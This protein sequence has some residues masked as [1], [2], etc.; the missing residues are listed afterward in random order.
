MYIPLLKIGTLTL[1]YPLLLAPLANITDSPYRQICRRQGA[2]MVFTEMVSSE[3][4]LRKSKK[5]FALARFDPSER[6]LGIQ[7]FGPNPAS[8]AEAARRL[9]E[10]EPEVFDLNFGCPVR[11]VMRQGAGARYM[12]NPERIGQAVKALTAALSRPLTVKLRTG[13]TNS[14]TTVIEAARAAEDEGAAAI[15]IHARSTEQGFRGAAN[16]EIIGQVKKAVKIPVIG[17][18]DITGPEAMRSML[19]QTGCDGVMI[20]RGALGNPWIFA[21]CAAALRGESWQAPNANQ[22][23]LDIELHYRLM[24]EQK[25]RRG[26]WEMR[27]HLSWY[28]KSFPGAAEFRVRIF[29]LEDPEEVLTAARAFFLGQPSI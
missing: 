28:G 21:A 17:N 7:L 12:E 27:K 9:E 24:Q 23:W 29:H 22:R 11:K 6:P 10:L 25:G 5:T 3:G 20:G 1:D 19:E 26:M 16:W 13:P 18:G 2:A 8:L 14:R 4:I 15:T